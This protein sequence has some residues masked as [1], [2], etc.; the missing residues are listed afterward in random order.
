MCVVLAAEEIVFEAGI[1]LVADRGYD[2][3]MFRFR[4]ARNWFVIMVAESDAS[5]AHLQ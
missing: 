3:D 2:S 5:P 1:D 4:I